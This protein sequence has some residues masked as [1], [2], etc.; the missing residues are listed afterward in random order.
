M[1]EVFFLLVAGFFGGMVN[2]VAGGGSFITFPALLAVGV[3]PVAANATNTFASFAGY[4][5]GAVGFRQQLWAYRSQL[6]GI[7]GLALLG[8]LL[9]ASLLLHTQEATFQ[10]VVPWLLLLAT[11]LLIRGAAMQHALQAWR[12]VNNQRSRTV[13]LGLGALL[14]ATCVYGGFFNAGLGIIL[15]GY[16]TLSGYRDIHLMN[17]IKLLVSAL[18]ALVAILLFG[19]GDMIAWYQG[20]VVMAGTVVGGYA[21]ARTVQIVSQVWVRRFITA[22]AFVTTTYFFLTA[23]GWV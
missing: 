4:V 2:T 20:S 11:V 9:G 22:V 17:G 7:V 8:G 23:Y 16:L 5:S 14:L 19:V 10:R 15:L 13:T 3:P 21:A 6:Y 1:T 12:A 18:V